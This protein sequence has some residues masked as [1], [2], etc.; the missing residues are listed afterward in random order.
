MRAGMRA[1]MQRAVAQLPR[2][3]DPMVRRGWRGPGLR[4]AGRCIWRRQAQPAGNP[5]L[6]SGGAARRLQWPGSAPE[7]WLSVLPLLCS[8]SCS[9]SPCSR[10]RAPGSSS[11]S[12]APGAPRSLTPAAT[13]LPSP[14]CVFIGFQCSKITGFPHCF[15]LFTQRHGNPWIPSISKTKGFPENFTLRNP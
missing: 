14:R 10:C 7:L 11:G 2:S 15:L 13:R 9:G 8:C 4:N 6:R 3:A 12:R 5:V 1:G